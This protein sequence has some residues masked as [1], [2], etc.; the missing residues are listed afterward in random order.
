M[1]FLSID[2]KLGWITTYVKG[3]FTLIQLVV[4]VLLFFVIF[5]G[6][7]FILNMLLRRTWLMAFI[8]PFIVLLIVGGISITEY[9]KSPVAS[10]SLA[11]EKLLIITPVDMIILSSGLIGTIVCGFV[12]KFLRKSGYQMF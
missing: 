1:L 7:A 4:S 6:L 9:F 12:I 5:F 3:T 8:Y 2:I 11:F 10:F